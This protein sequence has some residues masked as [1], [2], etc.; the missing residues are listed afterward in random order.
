MVKATGQTSG[1]MVSDDDPANVDCIDEPDIDLRKEVSLDGG[2]FVRGEDRID[3]VWALLNEDYFLR[4]RVKEITWHTEWLTDSD[5]ESEIGLIDVRRRKTGDGIEAVLYTPREKRT[6]AHATAVLDELGMTIV[7][8]RIV[9]LDN[10]RIIVTLVFM[11]QDARVDSDE[12]RINKVRR[13]LTRILTAPSDKVLDV[14]RT[15]PRQARMFT[16]NTAVEFSP[17]ATGDQTMLELTAAD[18]PGLLSTIGQVFIEQGIDIEAAKIVTIGEKAEDVFYV[19]CESGGALDQEQ[20]Q[21]LGKALLERLGS[22]S[23]K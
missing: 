12:A 22:A 10:K 21:Q 14:T 23:N 18:R 11:E 9:T 19:C 7:D 5:P 17:T 16:T 4:H 2:P 13:S 6:F 3:A 1:T 20:E 8:A 15:L